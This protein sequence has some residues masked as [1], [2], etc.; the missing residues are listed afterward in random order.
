M[1]EERQ[2]VGCLVFFPLSCDVGVQ[3]VGWTLRLWCGPVFVLFMAVSK[4]CLFDGESNDGAYPS[5]HRCQLR[6][7]AGDDALYSL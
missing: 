7:L 2:V 3:E 1:E 6:L 4:R 5:W